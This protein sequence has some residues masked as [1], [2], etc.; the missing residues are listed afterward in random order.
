[1]Q[2]GSYNESTAQKACRKAL[3][4]T[5]PKD[6][7]NRLLDMKGRRVAGTC[8]YIKED[9]AF[10]SWLSG[11]AQLLWLSG[12]PG[13]GKTM[14]SLFLAEEL[15]KL[16][17]TSRDAMFLEYYCDN[18]DNKRNTAITVVRG[19]ILQLLDQRPGLF[20]HILPKFETQEG[21]LIEP[22]FESLWRVLED[23]IHD[24]STGVIYCVIDGIDECIETSLELLVQRIRQL[25]TTDQRNSPSH[26]M[27]LI[28][29]S[30]E[31]PDCMPE[32]LYD[33]PHI[34]LQPTA[35]I[36]LFIESKVEEL[37]RHK[38]Y[39]SATR[40]RVKSIFISR[41]EGTFLWVGIAAAQ[42]RGC[43]PMEVAEILNKLPAG[44]D[45]L[46]ARM[47]RQINHRHR[48]M[49]V[50]VLLWVTLAV[51]PL[52]LSELGVAIDAEAQPDYELSIEDVARDHVKICR[53]FLTLENAM[54][55]LIHQSV[56]DYLLSMSSNAQLHQDLILFHIDEYTGN[57]TIASMCLKYIH[58]R[59]SP[60]NSEKRPKGEIM[61]YFGLYWPN[62]ARFLRPS[63]SVFDFDLPFYK[64]ES[65]VRNAW[66]NE[67]W[68]SGSNMKQS[69]LPASFS[70]L[71][72]ACYLGIL[73]L[74]QKLVHK[75]RW[76]EKLRLSASITAKDSN[77]QTPLVHAASQGYTEIVSLLLSQSPASINT[78]DNS[79]R[80]AL[81]WAAER[82]HTATV[83]VLL[84]Q[85]SIDASPTDS[86]SW[87]PLLAACLDGHTSIARM[88]LSRKDVNPNIGDR[89]GRSP[90]SWAAQLGHEGA[91]KELL[92]TPGV[93]ADAKDR[94]GLQTPLSRACE[95]GHVAVVVLLLEREGVDVNSRCRFGWTPLAYAAN[96]GREHV[97]MV[98]LKADGIDV[99]A[100]DENG[101]TPSE[102]ARR[103]GH[104]GI[105]RL[106]E[107]VVAPIRS[108][109]LLDA[110]RIEV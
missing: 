70:L 20:K 65:S 8:T 46:Y 67:Y 16:A 48:E 74:I 86:D 30:R 61:P 95:E 25:Y 24:T 29:L 69:A 28:L 15:E 14:L 109:P 102:K 98:L 39:N 12:G 68:K 37:A 7:R 32:Y 3:F 87:T 34:R 42:L 83:M 88:L 11:T 44:L 10:S 45:G 49:A 40:A 107:A 82:G 43:E 110:D 51:R 71:H 53:S 75:A 47:L 72:L 64:K 36:H 38:A 23:M 106:L 76:K 101:R 79:N 6:D 13:K 99:E 56:K 1:L 54:V 59:F 84:S 33:F 100:A 63:D 97:V 78:P 19:L 94:T 4:L 55:R 96:M 21:F 2:D 62:H 50:K 18:Q 27:K 41:S 57:L 80:T 92:A 89:N 103:A 35:D 9:E 52:S 66:L 77:G 105:V 22:S 58:G 60:R 81:S 85:T 93:Q 73:P 104:D 91:V 17:K 90:L 26:Q 5:D 31:L 108:N